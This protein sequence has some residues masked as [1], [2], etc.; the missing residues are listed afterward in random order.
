MTHDTQ[1]MRLTNH[2]HVYVP[3]LHAHARARVHAQETIA[4]RCSSCLAAVHPLLTV[5]VLREMR[6]LFPYMNLLN[7]IIVLKLLE[8]WTANLQAMHMLCD[9]HPIESGRSID[10]CVRR[11]EAMHPNIPDSFVSPPTKCC[12][13]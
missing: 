10:T 2:V 6:A 5:E 4:M 7:Q 8:P 12:V 1:H 9:V 3:H 13:S 11:Q